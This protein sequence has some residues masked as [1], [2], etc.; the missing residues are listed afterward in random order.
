MAA[1]LASAA[2]AVTGAALVTG[3]IGFAVTRQLIPAL[4]VFL[5]L[6]TAAGLLRL[7]AE[8]TARTIAT[9]AAIIALRHL[10][11]AGLTAGRRARTDSTTPAPGDR[12]EFGG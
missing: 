4:T 5:D 9:S 12:S 11:G 10:S 1:V 8:P 3:A 6:L 7:A 2:L